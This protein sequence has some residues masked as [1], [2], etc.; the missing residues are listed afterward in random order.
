MLHPEFPLRTDR[1]VIRPYTPDDVEVVHAL[2]SRP[3]VT[4]F[5]LFAPRSREQVVEQVE[6]KVRQGW[7]LEAEGDVL[8]LA[9]TLPDGTYLGEVLLFWRSAEHRGGELGYMFDPTHHGRGY[10]TE[11]A[12][13]LLPLAFDG[14]GLH[15]VFA[16][17]DARNGPSARLLERLG[18]RRE[19][20]FVSNEFIKGEWT[21]ELIYGLLA[22][23]WRGI[24]HNP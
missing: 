12:A 17:L 22:D 15:R 24:R 8:E 14:L 7:R 19:A 4:R 3:D 6:R 9:V 20:H 2:Q 5:L 18:M 21:D 11:A 23:E 10:A 1:L 16:R 13:A